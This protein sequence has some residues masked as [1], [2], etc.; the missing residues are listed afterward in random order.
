MFINEGR[1]KKVAGKS[2]FMIV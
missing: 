1:V 2:L